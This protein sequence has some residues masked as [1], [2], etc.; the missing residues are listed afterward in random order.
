MFN[1][2][3]LYPGGAFMMC[4]SIGEFDDNMPAPAPAAVPSNWNAEDPVIKLIT[5]MQPIYDQRIA[6]LLNMN[7]SYETSEEAIVQLEQIRV[8]LDQSVNAISRCIA[9]MNGLC[10]VCVNRSLFFGTDFY[11]HMGLFM[12]SAAKVQQ[13]GYIQYDYETRENRALACDYNIENLISKV[14]NYP[15]MLDQIIEGPIWDNLVDRGE[16]IL[17]NSYAGTADMLRCCFTDMDRFMRQEIRTASRVHYQNLLSIGSTADDRD[18]VDPFPSTRTR[19]MRKILKLM[20]DIL[21][22]TSMEIYDLKCKMMDGSLTPEVYMDHVKP[23]ML[24]VYNLF[25]VSMCVA[26]NLAYNLRHSQDWNNAVNAYTKQL[27]SVL[28]NPS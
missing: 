4:E 28:E 8:A 24:R 16:F 13:S 12:K 5:K 25:A 14:C 7:Y 11:S 26:L 21:R 20:S 19:I 17:A 23:M 22:R 18:T 9:K 27:I 2:V 1:D 3:T 15:E 6:P 10:Q